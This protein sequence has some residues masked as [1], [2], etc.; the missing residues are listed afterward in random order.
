MLESKG[1]WLGT[2]GSRENIKHVKKWLRSSDIRPLADWLADG[3]AED[4]SIMPSEIDDGH[5]GKTNG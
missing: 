2:G 3:K 4:M 1:G 5:D